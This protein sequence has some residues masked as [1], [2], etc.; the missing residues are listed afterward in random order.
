VKN[1]P[2]A[3]HGCEPKCSYLHMRVTREQKARWVKQ[4]QARCMK[5]SAWVCARLDAPVKHTNLA[6]A[7][8]LE[9]YNLWRRGDEDIEQPNPTELGMLIDEVVKELR[10]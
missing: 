9:R 7:N 1:K 10:K 5:L 4:A 2:N 6:L 8:D 3:Q